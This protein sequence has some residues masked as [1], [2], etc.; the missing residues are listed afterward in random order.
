MKGFGVG[1]GVGGGPGIYRKFR[2]F[3]AVKSLRFLTKLCPRF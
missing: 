1:G 2:D 3:A